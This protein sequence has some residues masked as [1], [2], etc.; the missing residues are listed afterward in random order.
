MA[1]QHDERIARLGAE[2]EAA[3]ARAAGEQDFD[4][5][6]AGDMIDALSHELNDITHLYANDHAAAH[7]RL[8]DLEG[9]IADVNARLTG[10]A[11]D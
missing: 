4:W 7:G 10:K 6:E 11:D 1:E 8:S 5:D 3:R 9:R 2:I